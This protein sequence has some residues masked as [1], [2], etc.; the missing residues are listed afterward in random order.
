MGPTKWSAARSEDEDGFTTNFRNYWKWSQAKRIQIQT[1]GRLR[2]KEMDKTEFLQKIVDGLPLMIHKSWENLQKD[3]EIQTTKMGWSSW[4]AMMIAG[5][6]LQ[7]RDEQGWAQTIRA[8]RSWKMTLMINKSEKKHLHKSWKLRATKMVGFR[9]WVGDD[10]RWA[11]SDL[12]WSGWS[13]WREWSQMII[14]WLPMFGRW[15]R[16]RSQ[17]TDDLALIPWHLERD[18]IQNIREREMN[19]VPPLR[20][21]SCLYKGLIP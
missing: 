20:I 4:V 3:V 17:V 10:H 1:F 21:D 19:V 9:W 15:F 6:P 8:S 12:R 2:W 5:G 7:I 18:E 13:G 14:Y 16:R 11:T